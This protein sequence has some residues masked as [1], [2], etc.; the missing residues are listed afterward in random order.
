MF[1]LKKS[2]KQIYGR[3]FVIM[4]DHNPLVS[5]FG[6]LKQVPVTASSRVQW[7]AITLRGYEY[8][9]H[10]KAGRSHDNVD[11]PSRL[12]IPVTVK[13]EPDERVLLIEE[14]DYS[15]MSAA[16]ISHCTVRNAT[17]AHVREYLM[18]G[19]PLSST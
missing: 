10:Y 5:L 15:P 18:R 14:L 4:T 3:C 19:W 8:K 12:P 7:W 16:Q 6:E 2:H 1:A 17:L 11:C 9:I 13:E